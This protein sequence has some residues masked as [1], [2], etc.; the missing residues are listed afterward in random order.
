[1]DER[2]STPEECGTRLYR[3][4]VALVK[5]RRRHPGICAVADKVQFDCAQKG[6]KIE[7][8]VRM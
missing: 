1:M 7:G 2:G 3:R 5:V 8:E 4:D 6:V